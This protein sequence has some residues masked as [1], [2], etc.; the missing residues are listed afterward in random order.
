MGCE[1]VTAPPAVGP[2]V[3]PPVVGP[4]VVAPPVVGPCVVA[5][6]VV[7]PCVVAPPVVGP[8]VV[9]PPVVGPCV[10]APPVVGPCVV[11]PPVVGPCVC[12]VAPPVVGPCVVA[13]PV[14]GPC[15]V[16][17]PV[18]GPCVVAPPVVGPCEA[19]PPV[20][21]CE[22]PPPLGCGGLYAWCALP[23][24]GLGGGGAGLFPA[25][26]LPTAPNIRSPIRISTAE[27]VRITLRR[28]CVVIGSSLPFHFLVRR[29]I[30]EASTC[31]TNLTALTWL[32]E[33]ATA[34]TFYS[35][36]LTFPFVKVTF[37]SL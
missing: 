27:L 19:P 4:C 6:P 16:A 35:T 12:M 11:A 9:A 37:I 30:H 32:G 25:A 8:C 20:G 13:R 22:A 21:P 14:V 31:C 28:S 34:Q 17:P 7:G 15:V 18:V 2:C 29:F 3:A 23:P 26:A 10:V 33:P 1:V 36:L 5:P 24:A